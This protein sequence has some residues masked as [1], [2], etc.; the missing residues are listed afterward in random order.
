LGSCKS[1]LSLSTLRSLAP[2]Q[3]N[4]PKNENQ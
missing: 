3:E 1:F 4:I 2:Q